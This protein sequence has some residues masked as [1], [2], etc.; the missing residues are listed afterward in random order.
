MSGKLPIRSRQ[1]L[2]TT[3]DQV[4]FPVLLYL[5]LRADS[6]S[7]DLWTSRYEQLLPYDGH[8]YGP[9]RKTKQGPKS[10][11]TLNP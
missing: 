1:S 9:D 10:L 8:Q 7:R 2:E 4:S 3:T 5:H 6:L 11:R